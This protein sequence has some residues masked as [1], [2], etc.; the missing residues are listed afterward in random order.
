M[1]L[2]GIEFQDYAGFAKQ[3][4]SLRHGLNVLVGKN[5]SGKTAL[6]RGVSGLNHFRELPDFG[7]N[8]YLRTATGGRPTAMVRAFFEYEPSDTCPFGWTN[9][10][11]SRFVSTNRPVLSQE[12]ILFAPPLYGTCDLLTDK[13]AVPIVTRAHPNFSVNSIGPDLTVIPSY[14]QPF[15][16]IETLTT[17]ESFV[18]NSPFIPR[19]EFEAIGTVR[20]V[21]AHRS[22]KAEEV[23]PK[24]DT[25]LSPTA[26]NLVSYLQ[27]LAGSRH[28]KFREIVDFVTS[29]FPEFND[30]N[31]DPRTDNNTLF[32]TFSLANESLRMPLVR[33]GTGV[34]QVLALGTFVI[35]SEPGS[36][37]LLDE[38]HSYLHP[39]AERYVIDFILRHT[40]HTYLVAT[41]SPVFVNSVPPD[42]IQYIE[43]GKGKDYLSRQSVDV[44]MVLHAVGYQNSDF[45]FNDRLI[46]VEG[47]SDSTIL[48]MLLKKPARPQVRQLMRPDF[49]NFEVFLVQGNLVAM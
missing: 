10:I 28:D 4:V 33:C 19:G 30:I 7:L 6:L 44:G 11:W 22:I 38:P 42:R 34:E 41:H 23:T 31:I 36:I 46:F 25:V 17:G 15:F 8:G 32:L 12:L 37:I 29:I 48:P 47:P 43:R 1:K 20:M 9:N 49:R 5:N 27:T 24:V 3:F 39:T 14:N 13:S 26:D 40:E 21:E 16:Q 45:A 35:C 2:I 18:K